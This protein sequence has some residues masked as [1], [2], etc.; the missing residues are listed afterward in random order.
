[1]H[2]SQKTQYITVTETDTFSEQDSD[3]LLK[4]KIGVVMPKISFKPFTFQE[5]IP[6]LLIFDKNDFSWVDKLSEEWRKE[7]E[8]ISEESKEDDEDNDRPDE[9]GRIVNTAGKRRNPGNP[10]M[11]GS[12]KTSIPLNVYQPPHYHN[13]YDYYDYHPR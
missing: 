2:N 3:K 5:N 12:I 9:A 4:D 6:Q 7:S 13:D 11:S 10:I 8:I 1:M